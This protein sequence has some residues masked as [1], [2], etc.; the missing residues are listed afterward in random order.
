MGDKKCHEIEKQVLVIEKY[1][2]NIIINPGDDQV[3]VL[4]VQ[5]HDH[6]LNLLRSKDGQKTVTKNYKVTFHIQEIL[7][8]LEIFEIIEI[9]E[10]LEEDLE[11]KEMV[12][13][14]NLVKN[15]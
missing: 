8:I 11:I 5:D 3:Q 7:G 15:I 13:E 1:E 9:P 10:I 6:L 4:L 14:I 12:E 2:E